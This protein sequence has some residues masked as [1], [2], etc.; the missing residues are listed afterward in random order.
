MAET[1]FCY[2]CATHHPLEEMRQILTKSGK[3]WRCVKSIEATK[4]G[5]TRRDA[6][7]RRITATNKAEA[8]AKIRRMG[9]PEREPHS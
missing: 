2:R 8:Q 9:N 1:A 6:Y 3:R 7:G 4:V 5:I